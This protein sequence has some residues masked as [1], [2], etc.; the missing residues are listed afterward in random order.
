MRIIIKKLIDKL[1]STYNINLI[2]YE[3]NNV[4]EIIKKSKNNR[5]YYILTIISKLYIIIK[6]K[7]IMT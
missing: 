3:S 1:N 5:D 7:K 2:I 4:L 6:L